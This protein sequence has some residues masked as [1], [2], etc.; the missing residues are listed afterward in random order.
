MIEAAV[1]A[2]FASGDVLSFEYG[3]SDGTDAIGDAIIARLAG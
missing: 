3:G 1:V 2:A